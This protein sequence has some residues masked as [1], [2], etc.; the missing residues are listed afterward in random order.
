MS[1]GVRRQGKAGQSRRYGALARFQL[2]RMDG[3]ETTHDIGGAAVR[4]NAGL[5]GISSSCHALCTGPWWCCGSRAERCHRAIEIGLLR[6]GAG[7]E[8]ALRRRAR[9]THP[10]HD[11]SHDAADDA[12]GNGA[13]CRWGAQQVHAPYGTCQCPTH[14]VDIVA[15]LIYDRREG[16]LLLRLPLSSLSSLSRVPSERTAALFKANRR[17]APA[18]HVPCLPAC[19]SKIACCSSH[20]LHACVSC[21]SAPSS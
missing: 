21:V 17:P 1:A 13:V 3:D 9:H 11:S 19:R 18:I 10:V 15:V 12:A 2:L 14:D 4:Q 7:A 6:S 5:A 8:I 16:P 20:S